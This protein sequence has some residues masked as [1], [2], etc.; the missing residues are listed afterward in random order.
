MDPVAY[1]QSIVQTTG[2]LNHHQQPMV[3]WLDPV[4]WTAMA[5][6]IPKIHSAGSHQPEVIWSLML[7]ICSKLGT[8]R[9]CFGMWSTSL[10]HVH[11]QKMSKPGTGSSVL[12]PKTTRIVWSR[13]W[14]AQCVRGLVI[15]ESYKFQWSQSYGSCVKQLVHPVKNTVHQFAKSV[16]T[17][18]GTCWQV[19]IVLKTSRSP[20]LYWVTCNRWNKLRA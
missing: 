1:D 13:L 20:A 12:S 14:T 18:I 16:C 11:I 6:M 8:N 19:Y 7:I 17:N 15:R 9:S 4:G 5:M 3:D 2:T 10:P